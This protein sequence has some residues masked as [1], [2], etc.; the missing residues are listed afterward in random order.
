MPLARPSLAEQIAN[1]GG[2]I[3]T[4]LPD[5]NPQLPIGVLPALAVALGGEGNE[6]YAFFAKMFSNWF[7]QTAMGIYLDYLGGKKGV[8]RKPAAPASG[9]NALQVSGNAG[10][11]VPAGTILTRADGTAFITGSD[12]A[13]AGGGTAVVTLT[14]QV[15][16]T[17]GNTAGGTAMT[18]TNPLP[19]VS[20]AAVLI[21]ALAGGA[22]VETDT[23]Y[24]G[25]VLARWA[26][27]PQGGA[28]NDYVAWVLQ[29]FPPATRAWVVNP[30]VKQL[31]IYVVED[32][33]PAGII[34]SVGDIATMQALI[35]V[36]GQ[37]LPNKPRP[38][39]ADPILVAP[40]PLYLDMT[41]ALTPNTGL[42]Q[43]AA[44]ANLALVIAV[45][46]TP[47]GSA[48][49]IAAA[50]ITNIFPLKNLQDAIDNSAGVVNRVISA[51]SINGNPVAANTDI[52]VA[53][54]QLLLVRNLTFVAP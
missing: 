5:A 9:V 16:G 44:A 51:V 41:I 28:V 18:L 46:A 45:D 17:G 33:N 27:P 39:M 14:A 31:F 11:D 8:W 49:L 24:R 30:G 15:P 23:A 54:G 21:G 7:P 26:K 19:N 1:V 4:E 53:T 2:D 32:L 43:A 36:F 34:P 29:G 22:A 6:L 47:Q 37:T 38:L 42:T 40:T 3:E 35:G 48:S 12:V 20:S 52:P 10:A 25:R 13:I 50:G